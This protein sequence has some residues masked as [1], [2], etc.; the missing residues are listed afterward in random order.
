MLLRKGFTM[1]EN[2]I[3]C[4]ETFDRIDRADA[5]E[6]LKPIDRL[7]I[8]RIP[9]NNNAD[10]TSALNFNGEVRSVFGYRPSLLSKFSAQSDSLNK[11]YQLMIVQEEWISSNPY[12]QDVNFICW[13]LGSDIDTSHNLL[14]VWGVFGWIDI[15]NKAT[16]SI[17]EEYVDYRMDKERLNN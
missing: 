9:R 16:Y 17:Y 2:D 6:G 10:S 12:L 4:T 7:Y 13:V 3:E 5:I 11:V 14:L 1:L 15:T 8:N